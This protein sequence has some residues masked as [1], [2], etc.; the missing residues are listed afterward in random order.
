MQFERACKRTEGCTARQKRPL[1]QNAIELNRVRSQ[2]VVAPWRR[3]SSR[4]G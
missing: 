4:G 2:R 3:S 1:R